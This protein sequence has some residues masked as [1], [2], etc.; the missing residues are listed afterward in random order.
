MI[1][2]EG[3][4]GRGVWVP[5]TVWASMSRSCSRVTEEVGLS[6]KP[7]IVWMGDIV[8]PFIVTVNDSEVLTGRLAT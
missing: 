8:C 4:R 2:G 5:C 7:K 6:Q 1:I 3:V